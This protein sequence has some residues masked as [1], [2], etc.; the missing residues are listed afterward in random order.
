M[1]KLMT[2]QVL[3]TL[4]IFCSHDNSGFSAN[5]EINLFST[6]AK[7]KILTPLTFKDDEWDYI[8][9]ELYQNNRIYSIFKDKNGNIKYNEAYV[10]RVNKSYSNLTKEWNKGKGYYNTNIIFLYN[11]YNNFTGDI[12]KNAFLL[13]NKYR[14]VLFLKRLLN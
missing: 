13:K 10:C 1:S 3:E 14:M 7:G 8:G 9:N 6:L 11:K 4:A 5:I 2:N 12:L